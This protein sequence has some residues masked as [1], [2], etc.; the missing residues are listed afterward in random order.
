MNRYAAN[1]FPSQRM[2]LL[3]GMEAEVAANIM[4][5]IF[6]FEIFSRFKMTLSV[7]KSRILL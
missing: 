5:R 7:E 6:W 3:F 4:N 1:R 2:P